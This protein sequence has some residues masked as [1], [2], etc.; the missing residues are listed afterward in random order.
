[1]SKERYAYERLTPNPRLVKIKTKLF[2]FKVLIIS[3]LIA[4][5]SL[6]VTIFLVI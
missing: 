4:N 1:M 2:W 6:A 5:L 3:L